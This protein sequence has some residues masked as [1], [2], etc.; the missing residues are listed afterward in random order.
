MFARELVI[1]V[2]KSFSL[3]LKAR[4]KCDAVAGSSHY[5]ELVVLA[6][7]SKSKGTRGSAVSDRRDTALSEEGAIVADRVELKH[8]ARKLDVPP[9]APLM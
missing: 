5:C 9:E 7:C 2:L 3:K 6:D 8:K 1:V 4:F